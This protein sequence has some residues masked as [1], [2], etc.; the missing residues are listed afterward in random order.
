MWPRV[1]GEKLRPAGGDRQR[2]E[3]YALAKQQQ[4]RPEQFRAVLFFALLN[5]FFPLPSLFPDAPTG[6]EHDRRCQFWAC[7]KPN[8]FKENLT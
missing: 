5:F 7:I 4:D 2:T 8:C 1:Q 3:Q 6:S